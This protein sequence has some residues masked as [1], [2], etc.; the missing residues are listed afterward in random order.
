MKESESVQNEKKPVDPQNF[1]GKMQVD[2]TTQLQTSATFCEKEG[3]FLGWNQESWSLLY[4]PSD[5]IKEI[6]IFFPTRFQNCYEPLSFWGFFAPIFIIF[7]KCLLQYYMLDMLGRQNFPPY[8]TDLQIEM[9]SS[10]GLYLR[11]ILRHL[12]HD[13]TWLYIMAFWTWSWVQNGMKL[14]WAFRGWGC[15]F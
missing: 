10:S 9:R 7:Q 6:P 5:L 15:I 8:F 14:L 1:T 4:R 11:I 2:K 13:W 12:I 3:W